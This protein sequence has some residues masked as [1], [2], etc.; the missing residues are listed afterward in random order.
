MRLAHYCHSDVPEVS[1][2]LDGLC[3]ERL[4]EWLILH[5]SQGEIAVV[6]TIAAVS[7]RLAY[8]IFASTCRSQTITVSGKAAE[9]NAADWCWPEVSIHS[10]NAMMACFLSGIEMRAGIRKIGE[11]RDR[12]GVR[13]RGIGDRNA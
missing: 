6:R 4:T 9:P 7:D 13:V 10:R 3:C 2:S 12:I 5:D 1:V 8:R 11:G